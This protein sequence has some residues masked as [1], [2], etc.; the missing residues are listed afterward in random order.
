MHDDIETGMPAILLNL[1][2]IILVLSEQQMSPK[3]ASIICL[4]IYVVLVQSSGD[5]L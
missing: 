4:L 5:L 1:L 2:S 3:R